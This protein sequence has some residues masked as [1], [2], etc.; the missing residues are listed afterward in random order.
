MKI[1]RER[2]TKGY[3]SHLTS[4]LTLKI[5]F[6]ERSML[7]LGPREPSIK[8]GQAGGRRPAY[9]VSAAAGRPAAAAAVFEPSVAWFQKGGLIPSQ[10][11]SKRERD[12][13]PN[14]LVQVHDDSPWQRRATPH[15]R[16]L[17]G[18]DSVCPS[19][20]VRA[21]PWSC[22]LLFIAFCY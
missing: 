2:G 17:S 12:K 4:G 5:I 9:P 20:S 6:F 18:Q 19:R 15:H 3:V 14:G 21:F 11:S 16:I 1:Q 22:L 7:N 8:L 13:S 10:V